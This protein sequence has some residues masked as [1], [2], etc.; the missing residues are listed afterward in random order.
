MN[1]LKQFLLIAF[2]ITI[3]SSFLKG[4]G[5]KANLISKNKRLTETP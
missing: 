4:E 2:I 1:V 3:I 5:L